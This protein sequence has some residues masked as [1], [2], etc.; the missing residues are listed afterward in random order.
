MTKRIPLFVAVILIAVP[1]FS[2]HAEKATYDNA[3]QAIV[4]IKTFTQDNLGNLV[5]YSS[6]SGVIISSDGLVLTNAHVTSVINSYDDSDRPAVYQVCI[7][8]DANTAPDCSYTGRL[9]SSDE[10]LDISLIKIHV[11]PS[12]SSRTQ[13]SYLDI[14]PNAKGVLNTAVRA[15]GYPAIGGE[16]ITISEG[17]ISGSVGK[18]GEYWLKTDAV[19]SFGSSGVT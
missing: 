12:Y 10:D 15:M 9:V 14:L 3:Y 7:T 11:I 8:E 13:F 6:G 2:V 18:Y 19:T 5:Q 17:T 4:Q 1:F 16:T